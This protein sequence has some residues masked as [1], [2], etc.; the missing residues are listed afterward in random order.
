MAS[1]LAAGNLKLVV[2]V[3]LCNCVAHRGRLESPCEVSNHADNSLASHKREAAE[4]NKMCFTKA[5]SFRPSLTSPLNL[6]ELLSYQR[7]ILILKNVSFAI[8]L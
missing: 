5:I 4:I 8:Q 1:R 7:K 6:C 2:C 3:R